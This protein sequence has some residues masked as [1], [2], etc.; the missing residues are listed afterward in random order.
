MYICNFC[1]FLIFLEKFNIFIYLNYIVYLLNKWLIEWWINEWM[2]KW[3]NE[4]LGLWFICCYDRFIYYKI[5]LGR[6]LDVIC[7]F[8]DFKLMNCLLGW[9]WLIELGGFICKGFLEE[10]F[11]SKVLEGRNVCLKIV[12]RRFFIGYVFIFILLWGS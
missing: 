10:G 4:R 9:M 8:E 7:F 6:V 2:S 3:M 5:W 12:I 1:F 11:F